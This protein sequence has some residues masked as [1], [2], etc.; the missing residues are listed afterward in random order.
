[1]VRDTDYVEH[2][3]ALAAQDSA[4]TVECLL[5]ED[6]IFDGTLEELYELIFADYQMDAIVAAVAILAE[7]QAFP[8]LAIVGEEVSFNTSFIVLIPAEGSDCAVLD[9]CHFIGHIRL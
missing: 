7:T 1:V 2:W 5:P 4:E 6:A 3:V 8:G 9:C